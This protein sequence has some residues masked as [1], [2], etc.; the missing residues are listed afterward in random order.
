MLWRLPEENRLS[1]IELALVSQQLFVCSQEASCSCWALPL[2]KQNV[3]ECQRAYRKCRHAQGRA[4]KCAGLVPPS[5]SGLLSRTRWSPQPIVDCHYLTYFTRLFSF[6]PPLLATSLPPFSRHLFALLASP[7]SALFC[8]ARGTAQSLESGCFSMAS[9]QSSGR[10]FLPE[11]CVKKG[12][13]WHISMLFHLCVR[14]V[15]V[16]QWPWTPM[17]PS[18]EESVRFAGTASSEAI[19]KP[20]NA[21]EMHGEC[22]TEQLFR[23]SLPS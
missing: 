2:A 10:I 22:V 15:I 12:Q 7:K 23:P 11:I 4:P 8:R 13:L 17:S 1:R 5:C 16:D 6:L 20:V 18:Q 21:S 3:S 19:T 14:L 9:P